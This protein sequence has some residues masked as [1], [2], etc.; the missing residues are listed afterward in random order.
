M[1]LA[2]SSQKAALEPSDTLQLSDFFPYRLAMLNSSVSE[3]I[4]QLYSGRFD[5]SPQEWRVMAAL[6]ENAQMSAKEIAKFTSMEK[7]QVSRAISALK[8]SG[9][10]CQKTDSNDRRFSSVSLSEQGKQIYLKIVPLVTARERYLLSVLTDEELQLFNQ[11]VDRISQQA[12]TLKQ[13]G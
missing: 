11:C 5:L 1:T 7:M 6:G 2:E 9:L 3:V 10:L 8:K 12:E 13:L 4:A